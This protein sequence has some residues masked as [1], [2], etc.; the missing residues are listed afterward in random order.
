[1]TG[2]MSLN[3]NIFTELFFNAYYT[4]KSIPL[5]YFSIDRSG[6][7]ILKFRKLSDLLSPSRTP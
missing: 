4:E 5:C 1:M 6:I 3:Y 7:I 2:R